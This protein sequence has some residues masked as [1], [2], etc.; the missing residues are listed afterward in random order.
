MQKHAAKLQVKRNVLAFPAA[1]SSHCHRSEVDDVNLGLQHF[2][3][4]FNVTHA[5]LVSSGVS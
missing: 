4:E 2:Y 1:D 5:R 3:G